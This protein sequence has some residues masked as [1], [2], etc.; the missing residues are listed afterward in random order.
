MCRDLRAV[1]WLSEHRLWSHLEKQVLFNVLWFCAHTWVLWVLVDKCNVCEK[2]CPL[3]QNSICVV[4]Q[5]MMAL[6]ETWVLSHSCGVSYVPVQKGCLPITF[7]F[8]GNVSYLW[9]MLVSELCLLIWC[10]FLHV[11][12][13]A[14]LNIKIK[15]FQYQCVHCPPADVLRCTLLENRWSSPFGQDLLSSWSYRKLTGLLTLWSYH[16]CWIWWHPIWTVWTVENTMWMSDV[17]L[18]TSHSSGNMAQKCSLVTFCIQPHV[19]PVT[20]LWPVVWTCLSLIDFHRSQVTL[21]WAAG[22]D[23]NRTVFC[24]CQD[25]TE[26]LHQFNRRWLSHTP[27]SLLAA[28]SNKS[29]DHDFIKGQLFI[30]LKTTFTHFSKYNNTDSL[31]IAAA[32]R[33]RLILL[34]TTFRPF[35]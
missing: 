2:M 10:Y 4:R 33:L 30:F 29:I 14:H 32:D 31:G 26:V 21:T 11:N 25:L 8:Q 24:Y 17:L 3:S 35:C 19:H 12:S 16:S 22:Q 6:V 9:Q 28:L 7:V 13:S 15:H 5:L 27:T 1:K 23:L 34:L 18:I 20:V